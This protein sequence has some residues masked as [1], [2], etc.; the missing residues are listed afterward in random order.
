MPINILPPFL[1]PSLR[2][3]LPPSSTGN[4][5]KEV[6]LK[7]SS[8]STEA[9]ALFFHLCLN[10]VEERMQVGREEGGREEGGREEGKEDQA[11]PMVGTGLETDSW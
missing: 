3:F 7:L 2:P 8:L 4:L 6:T 9:T 11:P 10:V 1:P 5:L